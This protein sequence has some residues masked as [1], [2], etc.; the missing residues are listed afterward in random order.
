MQTRTAACLAG[1]MGRSPWSNPA[2][3]PFV[4]GKQFIEDGHDNISSS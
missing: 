1:G 3:K 4:S 2:A